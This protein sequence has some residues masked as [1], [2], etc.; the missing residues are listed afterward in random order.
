MMEKLHTALSILLSY[1]EK[2]PHAHYTLSPE[3]DE[4]YLGGPGRGV[5]NEEDEAKLAELGV[6]WDNDVD[7][8]S[9]MV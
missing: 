5:V 2:Y 8:W 3:H 9:M 6:Y 4:I 7:S 1:R